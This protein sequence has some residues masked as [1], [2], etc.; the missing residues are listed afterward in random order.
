[1]NTNQLLDMNHK[2]LAETKIPIEKTVATAVTLVAKATIPTNATIPS[3]ATRPSNTTIPTKATIAPEET[4]PAVAGGNKDISA[5]QLAQTLGL[6][7]GGLT[8]RNGSSAKESNHFP[9]PKRLRSNSI[10]FGDALCHNLCNNLCNGACN[11]SY[12]DKIHAESNLASTDLCTESDTA[13]LASSSCLSSPTLHFQFTEFPR[14]SNDPLASSSSSI[15]SNPYYAS[16]P[17]GAN[18]G[19]RYSISF[20]GNTSFSFE[21]NHLYGGSLSRK[22]S[23]LVSAPKAIPIQ[24]YKYGVYLTVDDALSSHDKIYYSIQITKVAVTGPHTKKK[25]PVMKRYSEILLF[26]KTIVSRILLSQQDKSTVKNGAIDHGTMSRNRNTDNSNHGSAGN[27]D[28]QFSSFFND[29]PPFPPKHNTFLSSQSPPHL[30]TFRI[31]EFKKLLR[32]IILN[33]A[34]MNPKSKTRKLV[35]DFLELHDE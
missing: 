18:H 2:N 12:N 20:T 1:M 29:V 23:Y 11:N 10:G 35:D 34:V 8:L 25:M 22:D 33:P 26:Y 6:V 3:N 30:I 27:Q 9:E 21:G 31:K 17:R 14:F 7:F 16:F 19:K 24:F 4:I 5:C 15:S 28:T 32:F 13:T